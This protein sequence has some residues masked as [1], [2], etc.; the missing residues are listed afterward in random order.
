MQYS[1]PT[2]PEIRIGYGNFLDPIFI[3][4]MKNEKNESTFFSFEDVNKKI[5]AYS[6]E[7]KKFETIIL[8]GLQEFLTLNFY[9]NTIDVFIVT[10][11]ERAFSDPM[12][13]PAKYTEDAFVDTLT[14]EIIHRLFSDN[15]Q[16]VNFGPIFNTMF[17]DQPVLV[18]NH[19]FIHAVH[20][21]IYLDVLKDEERFRRNI[22]RYD[23]S[24]ETNAYRLSWKIVLDMGYQ[25]IVDD[26]K[27][28]YCKN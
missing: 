25:K 1:G 20:S 12:V 22:A 10:A 23:T 15:A 4:Y 16:K 7:W 2:K 13:I 28:N 19:I 27:N 24:P 9:Q 8:D 21:Y 11:H 6:D 14:H 5:A 17:P 18:R 3:S 26:L